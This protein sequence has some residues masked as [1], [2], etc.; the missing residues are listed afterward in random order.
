MEKA[1]FN[2]IYFLYWILL[3]YHLGAVPVGYEGG[4][5]PPW[6]PS[7]RGCPLSPPAPGTVHYFSA[8]GLWYSCYRAQLQRATTP[9]CLGGQ[10]HRQGAGRPGSNTGYVARRWSSNER[11]DRRKNGWTGDQIDRKKYK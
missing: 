3:L 10:V 1:S 6:C 5:A 4:P 7:K 11:T 9:G 8:C 2:L